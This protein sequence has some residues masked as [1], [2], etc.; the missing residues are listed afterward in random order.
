MIHQSIEVTLVLCGDV[1][2]GCANLLI[3]TVLCVH[4]IFFDQILLDTELILD[5]GEF[6]GGQIGHVRSPS[7][8]FAVMLKKPPD[9]TRI[10]F[11]LHVSAKLVLPARQSILMANIG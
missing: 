11:F 10:G 1:F 7:T 8:S 2:T 3:L 5:G 6:F 9:D 4:L